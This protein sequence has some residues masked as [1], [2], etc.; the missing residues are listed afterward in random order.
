MQAMRTRLAVG[1]Q[2]FVVDARQ[3]GITCGPAE[4]GS[5]RCWGDQKSRN[6][7]K[8]GRGA[9]LSASNGRDQLRT[10]G[11][12]RHQRGFIS[13]A[14]NDQLECRSA[15]AE[16]KEPCDNPSKSRKEGASCA[17]D[18]WWEPR[19]RS[20]AVRGETSLALTF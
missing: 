17:F 9:S 13:S 19:C 10:D 18:R 7:H 1:G 11:H 15:L 2:E 4:H 8:L 6:R 14:R 16:G 5:R 12:D 20:R 3:A